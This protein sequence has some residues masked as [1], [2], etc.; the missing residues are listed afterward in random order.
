VA[1]GATIVR[2]CTVVNNGPSGVYRAAGTL[3]VTNSILWGNGDDVTGAVLLVACDIEDGDSNGVAG[4]MASDPLFVNGFYLATNSSCVNAGT[5]DATVWGLSGRATRVDGSNDSDRVDLG[6]H[7]PQGLSWTDCYVA[8]SGNDTNTGAGWGTAYRTIAKALA[9]ARD[10]TRIHIAS[11]GYT[12][13]SESFPLSVSDLTGVELLGSNAAATVIN[14]SGTSRRVMSISA[15]GVRLSGLTF[16]GG[17][18]SCPAGNFIEEGGG[19]INVEAGG[20]VIMDS[21]SV[22]GNQCTLT[23]SY[24]LAIGGG[25]RLACSS[26]LITNSLLKGNQAIACSGGSAAGAGV[27]VVRGNVRVQDSVLNGNNAF[28]SG[29]AIAINGGGLFNQGGFVRLRD[30]LLTANQAT[31]GGRGLANG[32]GDMVAENCTIAYNSGDGVYRIGGTLAV[33]NSILWGNGDD[34]TGTVALGWCDVEDGDNNGVDGC[35]SS[36][37]LF[38][39][40]FYLGS[41]S[42]CIDAGTNS[43]DSWGLD[44]RTTQTSGSNDVGRV[45]L[46][47]H[48]GQGLNWQ[49]LYVSPGGSNDWSGTNWT[50]A[51]RTITK[52]L[53]MA[54]SGTRIHIASGTYSRTIETFPLTIQG[55]TGVE[56]LGTNALTTVVDAAGAAQ[57]VLSVS[58]DGVRIEGLSIMRGNWTSVNDGD[59]AGIDIRNSSDMQILSCVIASNQCSETVTYGTT[60]GGGLRALNSSVLISNCLF[61]ANQ[62]VGGSGNL[63]QGA[64]LCVVNG[65]ATVIETVMAGNSASGWANCTGIHGG[66]L[67]NS[68]GIVLLRNCLMA[69]N[70]TPSTAGGVGS[71]SGSTLLLNC[72][73]ANNNYGGV[74][75]ISG[76]LTVTNSIL[77]GNGDDATGSVSLAYCDIQTSDTFW[78]NG[79][80]GCISLDPL[81]VDTNYYHPQ[82]RA[83]QYVNGYFTGGMWNRGAS[84]SPCIDAGA[85]GSDCSREM[86]PNGNRVNLGYDGNTPVASLTLLGGTI[87][88]VR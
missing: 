47:Y 6:Y 48:Y 73:V 51:V 59:G 10:G 30:C 88:M 45:D 5:N 39:S 53:S 83:G 20:T 26:V 43:A 62:A 82:S 9:T 79:V 64:G 61:K 50:E 12:S 68:G 28:P 11:G 55:L 84:N 46:G 57:R 31:M 35:F 40:G 1:S 81:F 67:Y 63:V 80:N 69:G 72:T 38:S 77:W 78:T 65:V 29:S 19:G 75:R 76:T 25:L 33:T 66:G 85:R 86:Y 17:S 56:L 32:A 49:D 44:G 14:A 8:T 24:G 7:Y 23:G 74:Y 87:V 22:T 54:Q 60:Q 37:P 41:G 42:P 27:A 2:N 71:D 70:Q 58:G 34:A 15:D 3:A 52:A 36:D 18:F 13:S 4:C 21:C 16:S